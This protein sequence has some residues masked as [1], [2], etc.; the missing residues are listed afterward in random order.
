[1]SG[2]VG[3]RTLLLL[4]ASARCGQAELERGSLVEACQLDRAD[5]LGGM[6]LFDVGGDKR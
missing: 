5:T 4:L 6:A 1:M 2:A 3:G